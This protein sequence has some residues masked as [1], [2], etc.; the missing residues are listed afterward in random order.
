MQ[1]ARMQGVI[2]YVDSISDGQGSGNLRDIRQ[3]YLT[4]ASSIPVMQAADDIE[5]A[6]VELQRQSRLFS[7]ETKTQI[8]YFNGST[9]TLRVQATASVQ[10]MEDSVTSLRESLWLAKDTARLTVFNK[11][12]DERAAVI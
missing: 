9:D 8:V 5:E 11:E 1:D 10:I 2:S 12:A 7:E 6:R 3:D 4:V